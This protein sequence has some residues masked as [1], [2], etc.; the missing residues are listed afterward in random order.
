MYAMH[1][2][3]GN[4]I[5]V[6]CSPSKNGVRASAAVL[7]GATLLYTNTTRLFDLC[8]APYYSNIHK[9]IIRKAVVVSCMDK[10]SGVRK[11]FITVCNVSTI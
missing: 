4:S 6:L 2:K 8:N 3:H 7:A 1:R 10:Y 11:K 9:T 5:N